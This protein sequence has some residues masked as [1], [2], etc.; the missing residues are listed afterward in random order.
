MAKQ[1]P[2]SAIPLGLYIHIPWCI[3]KCP[4]CDFNSHAIDK[5]QSIPESKYIQALLHDLDVDLSYFNEKRS[6]ATIFIGGG[7]PSLLSPKA[8]NQLM[9]GLH[10]KFRFDNDIEI[11]LE[12]N[13]GSFESLKFAEFKQLGINRLSIGIQSFNDLILQKLGRVHSSQEAIQAV[14]IAHQ[15]GFDNINLD[16]MFGVPGGSYQQ[17]ETDLLKASSLQPTHISFYQFTLEP[18]TYFYKYRPTLQAH[19]D[20]F[21]IQQMGIELLSSSGYEH[22]EISAF[23]KPYQ[24]C[25]HNV[26]YWEFGD[27]IGIGAGAHGKVTETLPFKVTRTV[28]KKLPKTYIESAGDVIKIE[29]NVSFYRDLPLEY[30]MNHFRLKKAVDTTKFIERTGLPLYHIKKVLKECEAKGMLQWDSEKIQC[31]NKGWLFLD[32][33]L[34]HFMDLD[35]P[36]TTLKKS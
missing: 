5:N 18:G 30:F 31:T 6:L 16:L 8:L 32:E 15:N 22:Y 7:T 35:F 33:L 29:K 4:Y 21:A 26:N 24:Q 1:H 34:Q 36:K 28:K 13:P 23:A 17:S 25:K 3:K 9:E 20:V 27:Y 12:A 11:T 2:S 14:E 19:D 10:E